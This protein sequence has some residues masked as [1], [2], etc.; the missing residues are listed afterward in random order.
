LE[1]CSQLISSNLLAGVFMP[2]KFI[3]YQPVAEEQIYISFL[4]PTSF[5]HLFNSKKMIRI[6]KILEQDMYEVLEEIV[7]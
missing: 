2:V 7:F 5:A 6:A 3:V 1:N 4:K